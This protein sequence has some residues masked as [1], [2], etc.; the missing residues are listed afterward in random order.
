MSE[1]LG[2]GKRKLIEQ[3]IKDNWGIEKVEDK[4]FNYNELLF[5]VQELLTEEG[6]AYF[7]QRRGRRGHH[8]FREFVKYL[9]YRNLANY[10]S[11]ILITSEKGCILDDT[12]IEMPRDLKK[13]PKGI[14]V[15]KLIDKG[16]IYVYSFNVEKKRLEVKK[17]KGCEFAKI[18]D[19]YEV[20]LLNGQK[21]KVTEDHPFL[22]MDGSYKQLKDIIYKNSKGNPSR[23]YIKKGNRYLTD[24][25]RIFSRPNILNL[26]NFIKV[27]YSDIDKKNGDTGY[28]HSDFESRFIAREIFGDI[29]GKIIHH[30]NGN[31]FDNRVENLEVLDG[32][33]MHWKKHNMDKYK[34]KIKNKYCRAKGYSTKKKEKI[35]IKTNEFK[36]QC[37]KKR[38]NYCLKNGD[39]I[40]MQSI[41]REKNNCN[42]N[43]T[44]C[45]LRI[46]SIRYIGKRKTYDIVDVEDNKNFIA[47]GFVVSNTGKSSAAIMIA[48][49]WC[50][51]M[52]IRF[53]PNRHIAYNNADVMTKIDKLNKFEPIIADEAIRF[54]CISGDMSVKTSKGNIPIKELANKKNF[55]VYT[56]N[57]NTEKEELQEAGQCVKVR[58]DVVYEIETEDGKKIKATKDHKFLTINGWKILEELKNGDT[59]ITT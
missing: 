2:F 24:R 6:K 10:D 51:L 29:D 9:L 42:S 28:K 58:E 25:L 35:N 50:K 40:S 55:K 14:S 12:L 47:N 34:F 22:L 17:S 56:F 7:E 39:K 1:G 21:I 44:R 26:N 15:K 18:A 3:I 57:E 27:D 4:N 53:D 54:A 8:I 19:V 45:G 48:R 59:L 36:V 52:G 23:A 30:K 49:F 38:T 33:L 11:M 31:H 32:Q 13:Y 43:H 46:K 37:S 5:V 20:E 41:L 16:P